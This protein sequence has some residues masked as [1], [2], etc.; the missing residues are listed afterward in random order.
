MCVELIHFVVQQKLTQNCK[1]TLGCC[2]VAKSCLTFCNPIDCSIPG[3]PVHHYLP[4]FAQTH[5]HWV[6]DAIQ[7]SHPLLPSSPPALSLFQR[8]GLFQ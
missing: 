8:Q 2:S 4:E 5:V 6:I 3:S 1:V 7:P